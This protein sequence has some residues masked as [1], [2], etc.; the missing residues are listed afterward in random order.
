MDTTTCLTLYILPLAFI[1]DL[2]LGDPRSLPHPIRWMGSAIITLEPRFR[3]LPASPLLT[4]GLFSLCLI[5]AAWASTAALL[6]AAGMIHP[7]FGAGLE[8]IIVYYCISARSLEDAAM[9]VHESLAAG[10]LP[11]ARRKAGMIVGRDTN[12]LSEKGVTRAAVET[13]A[14]NLVDGVISPLFFAAIGG[15]PLAAAYKMV[16]TLDSMIGYKDDRNLLFGR[17]AARVDDAANFIPARLSVPIISLAAQILCKKGRRARETARAE[18]GNHTSPNAG[19][20]EAAFAGAL[21]VKLI[22]PA[23][24]RGRLV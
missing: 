21:G 23:L 18:G 10:R 6:W 19:R 9:D 7:V 14:E 20:P 3:K 4:G 13:V 17:V 1:L 5:A 8:I 16:N 22:G 11:E 2:V 24:Y 12:E 15:A